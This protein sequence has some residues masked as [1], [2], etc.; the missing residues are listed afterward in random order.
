[1]IDGEFWGT[2]PNFT[3]ELEDLPS[4]QFVVKVS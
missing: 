3:G 4:S 1:M 2:A